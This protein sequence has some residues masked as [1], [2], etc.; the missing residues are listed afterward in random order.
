[1]ERA[2]SRPVWS[3][4]IS[5]GLVTIPVRLYVAVREK[6]L[7][8][9]SLHDQDKV[10]IKQKLFCPQD[11]KDVHREHIVKGFEIEKDRFVVIS[12]E[13]LEAAAPKTTRAIEIQDFVDLNEI[14]PVY[15]DRP[16]YIAPRPEGAK[17][18][19]LLLE[20][21][22]KKQ[23]VGIA[24]I[25]MHNKEYLAALRPIGDVLCM[26]TMHFGDE[27]VNAKTVEGVDSKVKVDAREMK[28]AEQLIDSLS[29]DWDPENYHDQYREQVM[30]MIR[31]KAEGEEI[32]TR[33]ESEEKTA[34]RKGGDLIAALEASLANAKAPGK[35]NR[36]IRHPRAN[37]H[38]HN[39]HSHTRRRKSA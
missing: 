14:D 23:K 34:K 29:T 20:A 9:R 8:F 32:V 10:P 17:P 25:V 31:R 39:G 28:I 15:F 3:G 12:Q 33:P 24:R 6:N 7:H 38:S 16:Y 19:R 35:A 27:V 18:Y 36:T 13:E 37:G 2:S 5:F 26:E 1:M 22:Q 4:S 21:M 11:G 30:E